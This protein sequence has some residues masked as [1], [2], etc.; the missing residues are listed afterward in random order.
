MDTEGKINVDYIGVV[1]ELE[2]KGTLVYSRIPIDNPYRELL[3]ELQDMIKNDNKNIL[4]MQGHFTMQLRKD[5]SPNGFNYC[6][7]YGY[8][9]SYVK[10]VLY[11]ELY[12][13]DAYHDELAAV[14]ESGER[15]NFA[16]KKKRDFFVKCER[17]I[18]AFCFYQKLSSL[19]SNP[20]N[21][22]FSSEM[23]GWTNYNYPINQHVEISVSS[24]FG[25]GLSS[26]FFVN[27]KYKGIDILPYSYMVNYYY[28]NMKDIIRY[29][30]LYEV[31]RDSWNTALNFVVET[32]NEASFNEESFVKKWIVNEI[33]EMM[34][35][36]ERIAKTPKEHFDNLRLTKRELGG[37]IYVR[38]ISN[39]EIET[40]AIYSNEM[41]LVWQAE[42]IS[43]AL[44]FLEKLEA[45]I[46]IHSKVTESIERIK[47]I[48]VEMLPRFRTKLAEMEK[49]IEEYKKNVD[50][51][52]AEKNRIETECQPYCDE[53][54][55]IIDEYPKRQK[56]IIIR[57]YFESHKN[58][59]AIHEKFNKLSESI[60]TKQLDIWKRQHFAREFERFVEQIVIF[61]EGVA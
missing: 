12:S 29:T 17:Y 3:G 46:P 32:S 50:L 19:K 13:F 35:G 33:D 9:S 18:Q 44:L 22:M 1:S 8:S 42:K 10:V 25:Y 39:A 49:E 34:S 36:L 15:M 16:Q 2:G 56:H 28:A 7:P 21:K 43:G 58:F 55:K 60:S 41:I 54:Q 37:L 61:F 40:Y 23:I 14:I 53:I 48:N 26:Y 4:D 20:R 38:N 5:Y 52:I 30:R 51:E 45:L 24:N 59:E 27:L 47:S 11:P 31:C 57:E 6:S